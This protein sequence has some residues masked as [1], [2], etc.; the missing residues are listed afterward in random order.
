MVILK[1]ASNDNPGRSQF[2]N[3]MQYG[4]GIRT[5]FY[6]DVGLIIASAQILA[7]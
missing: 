5:I 1:R 4:K 7:P 6:K 3:G 2:K